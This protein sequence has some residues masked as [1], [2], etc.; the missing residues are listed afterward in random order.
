MCVCVL[1]G[2]TDHAPS[3]TLSQKSNCETQLCATT[4]PRPP[5]PGCSHSPLRA[6][7]AR[8]CVWSAGRPSESSS[9]FW[10]SQLS[11]TCA[12]APVRA[13]QWAIGPRVSTTKALCETIRRSSVDIAVTQCVP[14]T[15]CMSPAG[16]DRRSQRADQNFVY[17]LMK[18][19]TSHSARTRNWAG[20]LRILSLMLSQLSYRS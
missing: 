4:L 2:T 14:G 3:P 16:P 17:L 9:A 7:L 20:D 11:L 6:A 10:E 19:A 12:C 13:K 18:P 5:I 8:V 15:M 1:P